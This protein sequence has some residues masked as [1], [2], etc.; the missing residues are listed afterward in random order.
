MLLDKDVKV[1]LTDPSIVLLSLRWK[2]PPPSNGTNQTDQKLHRDESDLQEI[3]LPLSIVRH[4]VHPS[5]LRFPSENIHLC[6]CD[7]SAVSVVVHRMTHRWRA[8]GQQ[9]KIKNATFNFGCYFYIKY[10]NLA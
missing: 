7:G 2:S 9:M 10:Q 5:D 1:Y 3:C 8:P 4:D 6:L